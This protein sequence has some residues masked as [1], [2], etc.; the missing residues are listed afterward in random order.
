MDKKELI[1]NLYA[2]FEKALT[3]R[4]NFV[5]IYLLLDE[6]DSEIFSK[7]WMAEYTSVENVKSAKNERLI[8]KFR[9]RIFK[10]V[11]RAT[12]NDDL[13]AYISD[14]FGLL[15]D[16]IN[17]DYQSKWLEALNLSYINGKIPKDRLI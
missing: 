9:E 2:A 16:A 1:E 13:S 14:D 3:N 10:A 12:E 15:A 6:R 7:Q 8:E 17:S 11:F 5:D 4:E